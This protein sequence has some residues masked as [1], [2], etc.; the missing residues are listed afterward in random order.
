MKRKIEYLDTMEVEELSDL[1]IT[2]VPQVYLVEDNY[3]HAF[4][5]NISNYVAPAH[6]ELMVMNLVVG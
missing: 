4:R 3:L 1:I 6:G 2:D 5:S